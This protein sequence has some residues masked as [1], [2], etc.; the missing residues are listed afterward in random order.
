MKFVPYTPNYVVHPR[1]FV[2]EAAKEFCHVEIPSDLKKEYDEIISGDGKITDALAEFF[3]KYFEGSK[4]Y[5][6]R[7]QHY[8][9][10]EVKKGLV[11]V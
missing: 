6:L 3:S 10:E 1:E 4:E 9:D 11:V 2:M 5:W 7:L 8:Y